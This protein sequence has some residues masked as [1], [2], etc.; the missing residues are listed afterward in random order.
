MCPLA[1]GVLSFL[2]TTCSGC[3]VPVKLL[4]RMMFCAL[5]FLGEG[6]RCFLSAC[7]A[8]YVLWAY[9]RTYRRRPL[10]SLGKPTDTDCSMELHAAFS[11]ASPI[12]ARWLTH[13]A[14]QSWCQSSIEVIVEQRERYS[15]NRRRQVTTIATMAAAMDGP[16][17][18]QKCSEFRGKLRTSQN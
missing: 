1:W 2:V 4:P 7:T 9:P 17:P 10:T 18:H 16:S 6:G 3:R 11:L 13:Q 14:N 12:A 5:L 15:C 8:L